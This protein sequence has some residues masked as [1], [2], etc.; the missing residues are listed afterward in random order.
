M[1]RLYIFRYNA[2]I[3]VRNAACFVFRLAW[4][5]PAK[6]CKEV[7][8]MDDILKTEQRLRRALRKSGYALRKSRRQ[9]WSYENQCGY[10]I[11]D[12]CLN[13]VIS[14]AHY[15]LSLDDVADWVAYC[16]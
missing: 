6:T 10:M 7:S 3:E 2:I 16:C 4:F 1:I 9:Q 14:G 5:I 11:V 15:D 12:T 8:V 13:A